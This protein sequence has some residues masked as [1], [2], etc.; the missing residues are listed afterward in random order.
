MPCISWLFFRLGDWKRSLEACQ[1]L[2][3]A[4][5]TDQALVGFGYLLT[6]LIRTY[7]GETKTASHAIKQ[8]TLLLNKT[9]FYQT[10]SIL[11]WALAAISEH[12]NEVEKACYH[13]VQLLHH[14]EK[15]GDVHDILPGLGSAMA[16][17]A[18]HHLM[19]ES[20]QCVQVLSSIA[21]LT[22]NA[23][24][25]GTLS[26]ALGEMAVLQGSYEEAHE[27]YAYAAEAFTEL[28]I[29]LQRMLVLYK[30]KPSTPYN[31]LRNWQGH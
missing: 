19:Q 16:F 18:S 17:F 24:A 11:Y 31:K 14:W 27:H 2:T 22:G 8:A 21:N 15:T 30:K 20:N 29:P 12:E 25:V 10:Q 6:G 23:E 13:Y 1:Q 4:G 3:E 7:R 5:D 26:F 28:S 9:E